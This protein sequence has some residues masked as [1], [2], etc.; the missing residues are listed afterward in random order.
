MLQPSFQHI[1]L[2]A[3]L[4]RSPYFQNHSTQRSTMFHSLKTFLGPSRGGV[5][6]RFPI[7]RNATPGN[8]FY[9]S[10]SRNFGFFGAKVRVWRCFVY[11][12]M[13]S[14]GFKVG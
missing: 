14:T 6:I 11:R 13:T 8:G 10:E 3:G 1:F 7:S 4:R 5:S 12:V 2:V 9:R